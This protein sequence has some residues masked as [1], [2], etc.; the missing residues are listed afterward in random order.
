MT[1]P[2]TQAFINAYATVSSRDRQDARLYCNRTTWDALCRENNVFDPKKLPLFGNT[3]FGLPVLIDDCLS[4][5]VVQCI[6]ETELDRVVRR[7]NAAGRTLTVVKPVYSV[8]AIP[9]PA[10]TFG[11]LLRHWFRKVKR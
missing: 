10:P 3:A 7:A 6:A 5:G 2:L 11:A 4:D 9:I 8:P 1:T